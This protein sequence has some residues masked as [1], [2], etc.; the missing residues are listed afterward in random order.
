MVGGSAKRNKV[1]KLCL[2]WYV[3]LSLRAPILQ[4]ICHSTVG[5]VNKIMSHHIP[6]CSIDK[7]KKKS[8]L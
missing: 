4:Q 8:Q 6:M 3:T 5:R 7:K 1:E 2:A